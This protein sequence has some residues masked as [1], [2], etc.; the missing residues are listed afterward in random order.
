[1]INLDLYPIGLPLFS[2]RNKYIIPAL[3]GAG[4]A[5]V[6]GILSRKGA[7]QANDANYDFQ[8]EMWNKQV[9]QQDKINAQQ[10]AYQDKVNAE[11]R[12]WSDESA[13]RQRVENAGYNPYLYN[14]QA[15]ANSAGTASSANLGNSVTAG[16]ISPVNEYE[17]LSSSLGTVGSVMAQGVDT[18][19]KSYDLSRKKKVDKLNDTLTG[20]TG[21]LES[22]Q[23][24]ALLETTKQDAR[25][26]AA[27]AAFQEMEN[28]VLSSQ[29]Y[30]A[31]G[32]PMVDE[33][34][35]R[36]VTLAEQRE[37]GQQS[38]VFNKIAKLKSAVLKD[39]VDWENTSV[40][41][42]LKRYQLEKSN[43]EQLAILRQTLSNL[44]DENLK[45]K[46]ETK[47][48]GSQLG[49]NQSVIELNSANSSVQR[50]TARLIGQQ[51]LTEEQK[52]LLQ[53]LQN[54]YGSAE[55]VAEI[56]Q[57]ARPHNFIEFA[58]YLID[59]WYDDFTGSR[60][61]Y[62]RQA[63]EVDSIAKAWKNRRKGMASKK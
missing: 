39:Q 38:E 12:A 59:S 32:H 36:P 8:R 17:G 63:N 42:L 26:K 45:I 19:I 51:T 37:R 57:K 1:M 16:A 28:A 47:L 24:Q 4:A 29:A 3:I 10:M 48:L 56:V 25:T 6:G 20:Q 33:S 44:K 13:V 18:A 5:I 21:G 9:A 41:T 31:N 27:T 7:K 52:T 58:N 50:K 55:K 22:Q 30:D 53:Q 54:H 34:S 2:T 15:S 40:D 60:T 62:G 35:G 46:S 23:Q 49:V 14:G 43:P 11:N 61:S